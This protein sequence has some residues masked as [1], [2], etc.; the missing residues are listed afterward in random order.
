MAQRSRAPLVFVVILFLASVAG[1]LW[2]IAQ[3]YGPTRPPGYVERNHINQGPAKA[4]AD[5]LA[6]HRILASVHYINSRLEEPKHREEVMRAV[7]EADECLR[8]APDSPL[9]QLNFAICILR[10]YDERRFDNNEKSG[11]PGKAAASDWIEQAKPI[12][13]KAEGIL[14]KVRAA[15]PDF[16]LAHFHGAMA[17]VRRGKLEAA[18]ENSNWKSKF[19]DAA[20]AYLKLEDRS[21]AVRYHL[22]F[23]DFKDEKYTEAEKSLRRAV[24]LDPNHPNAYYSLGQSLVRQ[25]DANKQPE[26]ERAFAT[27]RQLQESIGKARAQWDPDAVYD[28]YYPELAPMEAPAGPSNLDNITKLEPVEGAPNITNALSVLRGDATLLPDSLS[29]AGD[30]STAA[31]GAM[32]LFRAD[33]KAEFCNLQNGKYVKSG[34]TA[35]GDFTKPIIASA[36]GDLD[37][38]HYLDIVATD[39]EKMYWLRGNGYKSNDG[40]ETVPLPGFIVPN[41]RN[42]N[43]KD[44]FLADL[45]ADGDL[46][47][48]MLQEMSTREN[49]SAT[50]WLR[51]FRNDAKPNPAPEST[52]AENMTFSPN[53]NEDV[54]NINVFN[55]SSP[56]S[57]GRVVPLDFDNGNDTDILFVTSTK[58]ALFANRRGLRFEKVNDI[59][60]AE[61][62]AAGDIDGDGLTD[63]VLVNSEGIV[64]VRSDGNK[65][66][67]PKTLLKTPLVSPR[68]A[69]VDL[70][71]RGAFDIIVF[72]KDKCIIL[73]STGATQFT[74]IAGRLLTSPFQGTPLQ[75]T[76]GDLD[77][78][79]DL[80]IVVARKD[81]PAMIYNNKGSERNPAIAI[82]FR[83]TKTNRAGIGNKIEARA[84]GIRIFREAWNLPAWIAVGPRDRADGLFIKWTNGIDEAEGD[85]PTGRYKS[86]LEKKGREGSCPF[87]YSWDG[88]KFVFITDAIGATPLGLYAAP[89]MYVPP[90]DREWLR[91]TS[92]Q[93]KPKNGKYELRFTEEMRELT[94]LDRVRLICIDHPAGTAI[95]PNEK[96][97]FPPF[98]PKQILKLT[99]ETPVRSA[100][101]SAG[102]DVTDLLLKEDRRFVKPPERLGYQGMCPEYFIEFDL[103]DITD[104]AHARLFL[105]GWFAWTNSSINRAIADAGI[106]FTP[107]K[108]IVQ[109]ES[110]W[111][112]IV[113]DAGFPAGM[114]KTMCV[115][116]S[117]KLRPGEHIV[118]MTT[119][120]ALYWDRAFV[121]FDADEPRTENLPFPIYKTEIR[122]SAATLR[123]RGISKWNLPAGMWPSEPD[124]NNV[125][126][127]PVYDIHLGNYTKYGDVRELL[128]SDDDRFVIFH[129]GDEVALEFDAAAP[130][131]AGMQRTF[132]LDSSGWAKDMDPNTYAPST[133]EPLPFH[134]M[135]GYPYTEKEHYPTDALHETYLK[136]WNTRA[137]TKNR[138]LPIRA[139]IEAIHKD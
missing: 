117:N 61:D 38:D 128:E 124:Y 77:G 10:Q 29:Q 88:E 37:G 100:V 67:E 41:K 47:L 135:S 105:T 127:E 107:P 39:G 94:Y 69:L 51:I 138:P 130:P 92:D 43:I 50:P 104:P 89:G 14:D 9:D 59:P 95:Y 40:F 109:S 108:F 62:A 54:E 72:A 12:L 101:D 121:N 33:G 73:R 76:A 3:Q 1:V 84:G 34:E 2:W 79:F 16:P 110:R 126:A 118:R 7:A 36:V 106:R 18:D 132:L 85:A 133:V 91:I 115:D 27:H 15:R 8:L 136:T 56:G 48:G 119:N 58:S 112:E 66:A 28:A 11:D 22:G 81:A 122:P 42:P 103:G 65:T 99:K 19:R 24:E 21:A 87:V 113:A 6:R 78:D 68:V 60:G 20:N 17:A 25:G 4:A 49:S 13:L 74:D 131:A 82:T 55:I 111:R 45:D 98:A 75:I 23:L 52:P 116:F 32:L 64:L 129:H 137:V 46:D 31:R 26:I 134:G 63:I 102:R 30:R 93:L 80:D 35:P 139:G 53:F 123:W 5:S 90:Q 114:Q 83:G 125:S 97:S 96:F 86:Y 57:L 71:N 70:E 44:L 120:I